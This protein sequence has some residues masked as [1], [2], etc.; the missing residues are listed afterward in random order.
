MRIPRLHGEIERRLLVNYRVTPEFIAP[1]LPAPFRPQL[2]NGYAVAGICLIRLGALRPSGL[3]AMFGM[4]SENAAHRIAVEWDGPGGEQRAGVWIPRRD[5]NSRLTVAL[6]GRA[7]PGEH[8]HARFDVHETD[9]RLRVAFAADDGTAQVG[10][11]VAVDDDLPESLLFGSLAEASAFFE[12]GAIGWSAT[13][14]PA[15]HDG[16]RLRTIGWRVEPVQVR[17]AQSTFFDDP[18]RY[19]RWTMRC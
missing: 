10:V 6:G 18:E 1:L 2:R 4:R 12:Q 16:L 17:V 9:Q 8:H 5:S 19:P 14:D 7:F 15:R 11:D 3:P 13:R